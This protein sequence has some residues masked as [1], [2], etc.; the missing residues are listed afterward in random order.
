MDREALLALYD[1]TGGP[2]WPDNAGWATADTNLSNWYGLV[3]NDTFVQELDLSSNSLKGMCDW[4]FWS[5]RQEDDSDPP[6]DLPPCSRFWQRFLRDVS[7]SALPVVVLDYTS[8]PGFDKW[9]LTV[10]YDMAVLIRVVNWWWL[11]T[12]LFSPFNLL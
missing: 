5:A 1:S 12:M 11:R 2:N 7:T 4:L 6:P 8:I 10:L 9:W 3:I